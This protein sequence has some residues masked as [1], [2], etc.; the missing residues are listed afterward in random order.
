LLAKIHQL[1]SYVLV[2]EDWP[3]AQRHARISFGHAEQVDDP[4]LLVSALSLAGVTAFWC[5]AG[6]DHAGAARGI[7][8]ESALA[9]LSLDGRPSSAYAFQLKWAGDVERARPMY[10]QLRA[11]MRGQ[12]S[13]DLDGAL[14]YS[15]FH[16]LISED[17][18]QAARFAE[19]SHEVAV[20]SERSAAVAFALDAKAIVA[21][22][23][24][25]VAAARSDAAAARSVAEATWLP[26]LQRGSW[27]IGLVELA[28]GNAASAL[29]GLR[30]T[31]EYWL[32]TGIGEPNLLSTFPLHVEA[33][34][35]LG[36]LADARKLLDWVE[37]RAEKLDR[38]WSLAC[39]ARGR[40]LIAD[41]EGDEAGADAAFAR[42]Y[43]QHERRPQ[44]WKSY[45]LARTQLAHGTILRHR[46][47]KREAQDLLDQ[48]LATFERLGARLWAEQ[49][50]SELARIGS[51]AAAAGREL[52]ETERRIAA[53]AVEGRSNKEIAA[54]LHLSPK[55]VEWNLSRIYAKLGIRSR[56]QLAA[57]AITGGRQG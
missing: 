15:A 6:I 36:E 9:Q 49:A 50:R 17:W 43:E 11:A 42:A 53:L 27:A 22:H 4:V 33:A 37:L 32:A 46:L 29:P 56:A 30:A 16:E 21:A 18:E 54:A 8:L 51:R 55:T 14:F 26:W 31:T 25:D 34:V 7:A 28:L 57:R 45:E 1:L 13:A 52:T 2:N 40:A 47:R 38:A 10:E 39:A 35:A 41:A 5:G 3:E 20:L 19:E 12:G 48:A 44:Q 23:R 24:G